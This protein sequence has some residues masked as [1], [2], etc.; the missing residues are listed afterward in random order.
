MK[1][2]VVK[3]LLKLKRLAAIFTMF[4]LIGI[5]PHPQA[6]AAVNNNNTYAS[7]LTGSNNYINTAPD[8]IIDKQEAN[9]VLLFSTTAPISAYKGASGVTIRSYS[10]AFNTTEK[11]KAVYNELMKN[12][13]GPEISYLSYVDLVPDYPQGRGTAGVW[14]GQW[15]SAG[16][17]SP[18]RKIEIFGSNDIDSETLA[19]VLSHEYGHHFTYYHLLNKE[20]KTPG[21]TTSGFYKLRNLGAYEPIGSGYHQW[22]PEEIAAEDYKQLF[23]SPTAKASHQFLDLK[24]KLEL[25]EMSYSYSTMMFNFQPQ[26]NYYLPLA[27]QVN[28]LYSYWTGLSGVNPANKRPPS[29]PIISLSRVDKIST[30]WGTKTSAT[31]AWTESIDDTTEDMEYTVVYFENN[32]NYPEAA[33]IYA[34]IRTTTDIKGREAVVGAYA[35]GNRSTSNDVLE[36]K[37]TVRVYA[38]DEHGNIVASNDLILDPNKLV[39]T[40]TK[41]SG[42]IAGSDRYSTSIKL[43]QQGWAG[44]ADTVLLA[45]GT[46]F[47]DAL[48]AAPLAKKY[49]A[50]IILTDGKK[51]SVEIEN[52]L[53]RLKTKNIIVIG[54]PGAVSADIVLYLRSKGYTVTRIGGKDRYETSIEIAKQLGDFNKIVVATGSSF[55]DALSIAPYA[56]SQG[57]PILLTAA[58]KLPDSIKNYINSKNVNKTYVIGGTGVVADAVK[59]ALPFVERIYGRNRYETNKAILEYFDSDFDYSSIYVATGDNFPDA[60]SGSALAAMTKS[61]IVLTNNS[62]VQ[63]AK[64]FVSSKFDEISKVNFI[65]GEGVISNSNL[66]E[67]TTK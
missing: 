52:E 21:N 6:A 14:H 4:S 49:N 44:T 25:N 36:S 13:I 63:M 59:N 15:T 26:E 60:L 67:I 29:A 3:L 61:P 53:I 27:W 35:V 55:P 45:T 28:G 32:M 5:A 31:L 56:A 16:K 20:G 54:G 30:F 58:G 18:G 40:V 39:P 33:G 23:G 11:L 43:S 64:N 62:N 46:N 51:L 22:E 42:R 7:E 12:T 50:P 9:E 57:T 38:K 37:V 34:P 47:P 66:I 2:K 1:R 24:D 19:S 65:G 8:V 17:L 10:S 48:S 41:P